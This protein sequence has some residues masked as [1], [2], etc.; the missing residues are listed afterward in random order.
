MFVRKRTY[1]RRHRWDVGKVSTYYQA[2]E[3][4]RGDD[5]KPRHRVVA[6]WHASG[7][8]G[9]VLAKHEQWL[10]RETA[11]RDLLADA[12]NGRAPLRT[13]NKF[14]ERCTTENARAWFAEAEQRIPRLAAKIEGI[15]RAHAVLGDW[16]DG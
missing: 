6:S 10:A 4:Y 16:R 14:P 11:R 13:I 2:I 5:G 9:E 7:S 8:L 15:K 1:A 12:I 3:S